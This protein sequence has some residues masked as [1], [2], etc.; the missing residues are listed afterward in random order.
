[1]IVSKKLPNNSP[2]RVVQYI[3]QNSV[4]CFQEQKPLVLKTVFFSHN[5]LR[6]A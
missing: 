3:Y 1:M 4:L 2:R 5:W 6:H